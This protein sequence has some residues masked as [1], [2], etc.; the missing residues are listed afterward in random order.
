MSF[1]PPDGVA[2][3]PGESPLATY[4]RYAA[5]YHSPNRDDVLIDLAGWV[6][7][8]VVTLGP[9][10]VP[11]VALPGETP[12]QTQAR[13]DADY[14]SPDRAAVL[15]QIAAWIAAGTLVD[16][17]PCPF[18]GQQV[19]EP[20]PAMVARYVAHYH[21]ADRDAVLARLMAWASPPVSRWPNSM[22]RA[23]LLPKEADDEDGRVYDTRPRE[24]FV[25]PG[26]EPRHAHVDLIRG[27]AFTYLTPFAPSDINPICDTA[28]LVS[29]G[30]NTNFGNRMW[31][32]PL[33]PLYPG[34]VQDAFLAD[35]AK[36]N[37]HLLLQ[38]SLD[39]GRVRATC[40]KARAAGL[41]AF[42]FD[43]DV[44]TF[45]DLADVIAGAVIGLE[46]DKIGPAA[47]AAGDLDALIAETCTVC[48]P[49]GIRV[50]LH[51]TSSGGPRHEQ[52]WAFPIPGTSYT[53]WWAQN[54]RLGVTGLMYESWM[55]YQ[56]RMDS[57]G[58][59][60][61]MMFYARQGLHY[62]SKCLLCAC[63]IM[64][65]PPFMGL[66]D[67]PFAWRRAAE[68]VCCPNGGIAGMAGVTGSFNGGM[69]DWNGQLI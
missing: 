4:L 28:W 49:K 26:A 8:A 51:F 11:I 19:V 62:S 66:V 52:H 10:P 56:G 13:Y 68:M 48:V 33:L 39:R 43:W 55:D 23:P 32:T 14:H 31:Y 47:I 38:G 58:K 12:P 24:F 6:R 44:A 17:G 42:V 27:D 57:A 2:A 61:A 16:A 40:E 37:T 18:G 64:S 5:D 41:Y 25:L 22:P 59:M 69:V 67:G 34:D 36:Y 1:D 45:R 20:P 50:W 30:Q 3:Q 9:P 65:A 63:E 15:A 46:V 35:Y 29:I 21:A 53:N 60:G 54:D 7:R